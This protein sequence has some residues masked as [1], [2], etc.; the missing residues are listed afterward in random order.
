MIPLLVVN[1]NGEEVFQGKVLQTSQLFDV[2]VALKPSKREEWVFCL[3]GE[4]THLSLHLILP[5]QCLL[6]TRIARACFE[7]RW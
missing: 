6:N 3:Q 1:L 5:S 7:S 2:M 4:T